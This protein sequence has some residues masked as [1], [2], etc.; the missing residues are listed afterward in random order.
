MNLGD[1]LTVTIVMGT[2]VLLFATLAS[3]YKRYLA[4]LERK[5]ELAADTHALKARESDLEERLRPLENLASPRR[6][7]QDSEHQL[8]HP[9]EEQ[10][11]P[12]LAH[13]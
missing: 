3:A 2:V 13:T 7:A 5:L 4:Y 8:T 9:T 10:A 11:M 1:L 6:D 12:L